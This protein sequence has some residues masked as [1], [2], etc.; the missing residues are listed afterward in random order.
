VTRGRPQGVRDSYQRPNR[1]TPQSV[2][3]QWL[4]MRARRDGLKLREIAARLAFSK[5]YVHQVVTRLEAQC[6]DWRDRWDVCRSC[7]R[8]RA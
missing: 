8:G 1:T 3:E 7:G 2:V 4:I 5:Q 6:S